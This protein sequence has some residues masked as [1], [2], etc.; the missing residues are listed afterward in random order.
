[1]SRHSSDNLD[2]LQNL[3]DGGA[4][5]LAVPVVGYFRDPIESVNLASEQIVQ[6]VQSLLKSFA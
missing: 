6:S 4:V 1:M 5:A 3:E 2:V